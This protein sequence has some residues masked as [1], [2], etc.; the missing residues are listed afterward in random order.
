MDVSYHVSIER[1]TKI[2]HLL[3]STYALKLDAMVK[4][5]PVNEGGRRSHVRIL[6]VKHYGPLL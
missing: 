1:D 5:S 6:S 3:N 4:V 2:Y